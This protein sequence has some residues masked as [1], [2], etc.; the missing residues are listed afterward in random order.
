MDF[1]F[2]QGTFLNYEPEEIYNVNRELNL[3][4][5][6]VEK[7]GENLFLTGRAG[8]GKTTFLKKLR[9]VTAKR[10][11]VLAPTGVAAIN[12][13]G[14]TIH[15]FF[16]LPLTPFIPGKGHVGDKKYTSLS[17][18]KKKLISTLS[19]LVIDEISMVRPDTLDAVDHLL[20]RMRRDN[21]PFGGVQLLLIGDLRQ[22]P[23]VV[24]PD[25]WDLIK[26]HYPTPYFFESH[27]LRSAGYQTVELSMVYR[28]T[29]RKFLD[30]LNEIR[31]GKA[32]AQT[33]FE[34]NR[35]YLPNF[36]ADGHSGYIRLMTHNFQAAAVNQKKL[37]DLPGR[38]YEF[39][40]VVKGDFPESSYPAERH[41]QLKEGAQVMFIKN[42]IGVERRYYNGMIGTVTRL[43][44][45][46]IMVMPHE[47]EREIEVERAEWEN[48]RY[49]ID[50]A[51]SRV[52]QETLGT[53]SQYP[54]QLAWAITI[55][56]SQ[57]LTFDKAIIDSSRSFAPGQTYV[58][59]SRCRSLEG[60]VLCN[61]VPGSAII[62]DRDVNSFM[63]FCGSNIPDASKVEAFKQIYAHNLI[64]EL[65][66]F[67]ALRHAFG[68]FA[69]YAREY[70]MPMMPEIGRELE[71]YENVIFNDLYSV[72]SRFAQSLRGTA[73]AEALTG[74]DSPLVARIKNGCSYFLERLDDMPAF[75]KSLHCDIDNAEYAARLNNTYEI[76]T[77]LLEIKIK[78]LRYLEKVD[79]SIESYQDAL[80]NAIFSSESD[81]GSIIP[82]FGKPK[83]VRGQRR[84]PKG[85]S[86]FET[87]RLMRDGKDIL[88]IADERGLVVGTI[89]KHI[90]Q[91]IDL[92]QVDPE[93]IV[94]RADV[95]L[96]KELRA[97]H[98]EARTDELY[99]MLNERR[100][101]PLPS[102]L[103]TICYHLSKA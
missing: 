3:A 103:L 72:G 52:A 69:R 78:L 60:L 68:E 58:A 94:D 93:G 57:G 18:I 48:T 39:E 5:N 30:I 66:D 6:I 96:L 51:T 17:R 77:Y 73:V 32:T 87:L 97:C 33:L 41:L 95:K 88:Q 65:F 45:D 43:S 13:N 56:K 38:L 22:L 12:A 101:T 1:E 54:L 24:R 74:A 47:G 67:N 79:F 55:H 7:T 63:E 27:A 84:K 90:I 53:F 80:A 81:T 25:E 2:E 71:E 31:D 34:L 98:P 15:S 11:V 29:D 100:G 23:P 16:Q 44:N 26:D 89:A 42:D 50:K 36:D 9:A 75:L 59:L 83:H 49:T 8:T 91:L 40:A 82:Q 86:A 21:R 35:R 46:K 92:N 70:I 62:I 19:L 64:C 85:Y 37:D 76:L 102:H 99:D 20:R 10:M 61:P 4:W 28:Q 14:S